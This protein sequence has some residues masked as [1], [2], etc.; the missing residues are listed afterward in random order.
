MDVGRD[1]Y[2]LKKDGSEFPIEIGLN[3][4]ETDDGQM[5]LSASSTSPL[6]ASTC[7][8]LSEL[9]Y[10][11]VE[12]SSGQEALGLLN[13][14]QSFDLLVTDHLM[15]GMTGADLMRAVR[16]SRP[17]LLSLIISGY[18]EVAGIEPGIPRLT[19]PFRHAELAESLAAL[20]R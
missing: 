5:V 20:A 11:V 9:G 2:G 10:D 6:T 7:E 8:M 1:L 3:P 18:A 12:A 4:I 19:K 16:K 15:P 17:N 13:G 14:S